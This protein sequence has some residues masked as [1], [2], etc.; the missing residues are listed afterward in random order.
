MKQKL[1]AQLAGRIIK[2]QNN[3]R[4]ESKKLC[5]TI[6]HRQENMQNKKRAD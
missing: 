3:K 4:A 1:A 6:S 5:R 2:G